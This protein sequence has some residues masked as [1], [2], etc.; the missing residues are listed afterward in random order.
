[1][2]APISYGGLAALRGVGPVKTEEPKTKGRKKIDPDDDDAYPAFANDADLWKAHF[3]EID[4]SSIGQTRFSP[5]RP[6]SLR[7]AR[8]WST[9]RI[10]IRRKPRTCGSMW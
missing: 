2:P 7:A 10:R 6:R 9:I 8:I 1:M 5:A 4:D 3:A